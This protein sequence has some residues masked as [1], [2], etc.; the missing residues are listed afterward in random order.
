MIMSGAKGAGNT[1]PRP[2]MMEYNP[3]PNANLREAVF[4]GNEQNT[5]AINNFAGLANTLTNQYN[6]GTAG[7]NTQMNTQMGDAYSGYS[8]RSRNLLNA[9]G[10]ADQDVWARQKANAYAGLDSG[11]SNASNDLQSQL[12]SRGLS[13]S[14]IG[15]RAMGD[16]A[17]S[18]MRAGTQVGV[19][20]HNQAIGL[21]DMRRNTQLSGEGNLYGAQLNNLSGAYGRNMGQLGQQ[22]GTNM[23][24]QGQNLQN[25]LNNTQQRQANL[26]GYNQLG[27]GMSGM[28]NNY[29]AQAGTG[30]GSIGRTAGQTALGLGQNAVAY[31]TGM[32]NAQTGFSGLGADMLGS[33]V[34]MGAGAGKGAGTT[35]GT[36]AMFSD[37]R[38]KKDL[39]PIANISDGITLYRWTWTDEAKLLVGDAPNIG[40]IAQEVQKVMPEAIS[41]DDRTGYLQVNYSMVFKG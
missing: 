33:A 15:A 29:L 11:F 22:Y 18:R 9:M 21:S 26:M 7:L 14:G 3:D 35:A 27:R 10:T 23:A 13:N 41:M 2:Q 36:M 39:I 34:G 19:D 28:A 17:Q 38:L 6:Q 24:V 8:D 40:V 30:Y 25:T 12:A 16:L 20:A 1:A 32:N 37:K 4:L 31:N 5:A